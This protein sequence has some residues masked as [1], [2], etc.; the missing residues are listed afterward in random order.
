MPRFCEGWSAA[1]A[2]W[3]SSPRKTFPNRRKSVKFGA[4]RSRPGACT[5]TFFVSTSAP[6]E[7]PTGVVAVSRCPKTAQ[8]ELSSGRR[9]TSF[10]ARSS[11]AVVKEQ[12]I[13]TRCR[14]PRPQPRT[15]LWAPTSSSSSGGL[16]RQHRLA[17]R[18][19][20]AAKLLPGSV[21]VPFAGFGLGTRGRQKGAKVILNCRAVT[22]RE[23]TSVHAAPS[24]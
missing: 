11:V 21:A 18:N 10:Q 23:T 19:G 14:R 15:G 16:F 8:V 5:C 4:V 17:A 12:S 24:G 2:H 22:A 13:A 9:R 7:G 3:M 6:F 1:L 20:S